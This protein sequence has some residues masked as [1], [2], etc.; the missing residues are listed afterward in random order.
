KT[1][2]A[3]GLERVFAHGGAAGGDA[4][5]IRGKDAG[6]HAEYGGL[7]GAVRP[8]QADDFSVIHREI[9]IPHRDNGA[10]S[11]LERVRRHSWLVSD[12]HK[13]LSDD[14]FVLQNSRRSMVRTA[15]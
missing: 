8:E 5:R 11:F 15:K 4:S 6:E 3:P 12:G 9:E 1:D 7:A 10:E 13:S 2:A 14:L